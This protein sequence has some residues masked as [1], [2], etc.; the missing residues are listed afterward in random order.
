MYMVVSSETG[1][2]WGLAESVLLQLA[3]LQRRFLGAAAKRRKQ[4]WDVEL[5]YLETARSFVV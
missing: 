3:K 1:V 5:C 2:S 4:K